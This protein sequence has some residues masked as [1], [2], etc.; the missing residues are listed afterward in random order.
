MKNGLQ[1]ALPAILDDLVR[2]FRIAN[3]TRNP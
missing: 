3:P 1:W 2:E